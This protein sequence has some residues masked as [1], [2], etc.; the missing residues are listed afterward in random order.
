M[1]E[2]VRE[3]VLLIGAFLVLLSGLPVSAQV[4]SFRPGLLLPGDKEAHAPL[5]HRFSTES[6]PISSGMMEAFLPKIPNLEWGFVY[7]FGK[8]LR[9]GLFSADYLL[10][11]AS[12]AR[13]V[14]FVEAHANYLNY[15][16]TV[17]LP[18][19]NNFWRQ[20]APGTSDRFD[21]SIG[22]GCRKMFG[23]SHFL[24]VNAFY[25]TTCLFG[26]WRS[27]GGFG[28]EFD[29]FL[30]GDSQIDLNF[31]YYADAYSAFNSR[32]SVFPTFNIIDG[33]MDGAGNFDIEAGYSQPLFDSALDLRV[34][35][36]G[37]QFGVGSETAR[38]FKT[39]IDLTTRD[40]FFRMTAQYGHDS[41][42]GSYGQVGGYVTTGFHFENLL[43]G[44]NPFSRPEP[45]FASPRNPRHVLTQKVRRNWQ[46]SPVALAN[47]GCEGLPDDSQ[48]VMPEDNACFWS[49]R[50]TQNECRARGY[51]VQLMTP[52]GQWTDLYIQRFPNSFTDT[53]EE[54]TR[55]FEPMWI[56]ASAASARQAR[57]L[58][59]VFLNNPRPTSV[60]FTTELPSLLS[61]PNVSPVWAYYWNGSAWDGPVVLKP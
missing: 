49:G 45:V 50:T 40:G 15:K 17:S 44:E 35:L 28:L 52:G 53:D 48:F 46:R 16:T 37:Y 38:G 54:Y 31:N 10:P 25:D 51:T 59:R 5:T 23:Q 36:T 6:V 41:V 33:I 43:K 55:D 22:A 3:I 4:D 12:D 9:Q 58:V 20:G 27:S 8:N 47:K 26:N 56:C 14:M 11:V 24:G 7:T 57:G 42:V 13:T 29:S 39:G 18:F 61:N 19:L 60:F 30:F 32:G 34:Q 2:G 1:T 21:F